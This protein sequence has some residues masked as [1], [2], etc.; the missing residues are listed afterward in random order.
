MAD[1]RE[2]LREEIADA[3]DA[4]CWGAPRPSE[5]VMGIVWPLLQQAGAERDLLRAERDDLA[6]QVAV[7]RSRLSVAEGSHAR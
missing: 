1:D 2:T 3:I 7:L 4:G 5:R 6:G